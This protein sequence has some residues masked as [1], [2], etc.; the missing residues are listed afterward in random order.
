[1]PCAKV[2]PKLH[3]VAKSF[4]AAVIFPMFSC[5]MFAVI[6]YFIFHSLMT[7]RK[8]RVKTFSKSKPDKLYLLTFPPPQSPSLAR[9]K[10][11]VPRN[12]SREQTMAVISCSKRNECTVHGAITAATHLAMAKILQHNCASDSKI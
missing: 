7:I 3:D 12:L 9:T 10:C 4:L 2:I 6:V 1:M 5:V 11:A 8:L